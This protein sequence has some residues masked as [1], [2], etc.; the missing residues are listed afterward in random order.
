MDFLKNNARYIIGFI[1]TAFLLIILVVL[2][3]GGNSNSPAGNSRDKTTTKK[4][5]QDYSNTDTVV[6]MTIDGPV[7]AQQVHNQVVITVGRANTTFN[8]DEGY[9]GAVIKSQS[10]ANTETSY[11]VFLNALNKAGFDRGDTSK[12]LQNVRGYCPTSDRYIFEVIENGSTIQRFWATNCSGTPK[13]Y[14]GSLG[15]TLSLFR[16]QVPD[17]GSLVGDARI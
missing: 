2:L 4:V 15:L 12:N 9:D 17:Y 14:L 6:R 11:N 8:V 5:L 1:V 3:L 7:T 10:F 13:T 16:S